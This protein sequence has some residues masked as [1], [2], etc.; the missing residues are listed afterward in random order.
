MT[1]PDWVIVIVLAGSAIGGLAQG[2]FRTACSLIGLI[3]GLSLAA[4][5][6]GRVA[7][8]FQP[9]VRIEA[10]AN[11]IGFFLIALIVMA[12]ANAIGT[13]L[14]RI[15]SKIGLGCLDSLAGGVLG[16]FQG[17]VLVT[18]A[19]LVTVAF[20]PQAEWLARSRL[21]RQF[22]GACHMSAHLSPEEL[23]DKVRHGLRLLEQ[24]TPPWMHPGSGPA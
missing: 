11:V 6:Y 14:S 16:F 3:F 18:L 10:I 4:W 19:I 13:I 12:I 20:F 5:N 7:A 15:L 1:W 24:E 22:F 21:A 17:V 23:A 9:L 2:F 8:L